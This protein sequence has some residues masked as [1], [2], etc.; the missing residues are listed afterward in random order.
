VNNI[1]NN[2]VNNNITRDYSTHAMEI[3]HVILD[4]IRE[5]ILENHVSLLKML[6]PLV[7]QN[8]REEEF[9]TMAFDGVYGLGSM[10]SASEKQKRIQIFLFMMESVNV[11]RNKQNFCKSLSYLLFDNVCFQAVVSVLHE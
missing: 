4:A 2:I 6:W 9:F 3:H 8:E 5:C 11:E 1:G 10:S 7:S